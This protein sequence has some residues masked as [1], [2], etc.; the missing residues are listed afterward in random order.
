[1]LSI[2]K[3]MKVRIEAAGV[4]QDPAQELDPEILMMVPRPPS[5]WE[6]CGAASAVAPGRLPLVQVTNLVVVE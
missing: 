6:G 3:F 2:I 4:L 1:M 5:V